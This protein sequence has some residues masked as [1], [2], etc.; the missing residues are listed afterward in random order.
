MIKKNEKGKIPKAIYE[1]YQRIGNTLYPR[2]E[3]V[4]SAQY[5]FQ[6]I[7]TG[8]YF[9]KL[10]MGNMEP[11]EALKK[12]YIY[13][14][15]LY[16]IYEEKVKDKYIDLDDDDVEYLKIFNVHPNEKFY[17]QRLESFNVDID[18]NGNFINH[19]LEKIRKHL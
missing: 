12:A 11:V 2:E 9:T 10:I 14:Q 18:K 4:R 1:E 8:R 3:W 13:E 5:L 6:H 15:E 16:R 19:H 17:L 7:E